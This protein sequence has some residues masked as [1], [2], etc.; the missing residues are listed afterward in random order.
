MSRLVETFQ[1][2]Q[3]IETA[4][5]PKDDP[6]PGG[7]PRARLAAERL[8]GGAQATEPSCGALLGP[9]VA[10][11]PRRQR[12]KL[13][14]VPLPTALL[15]RA[16]PLLCTPSATHAPAPPPPCTPVYLLDEI[17]E[18]ARASPEQA[19]AVADAVEKKLAS[20]SPVVKFK[21]RGRGGGGPG[22][23]L[24]GGLKARAHGRGSRRRWAGLPYSCAAGT[25]PAGRVCP[26]LAWHPHRPG[27]AP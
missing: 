5:L 27:R 10:P 16:C 21:A 26:P 3:K 7:R 4:C 1:R 22:K 9:G 24:P 19:Q 13:A 8:Q 12:P 20:K 11:A 17:L 15:L 25:A 6:A 2:L 14:C 18:I 23:G